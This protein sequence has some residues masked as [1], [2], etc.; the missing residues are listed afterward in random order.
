MRVICPLLVQVLARLLF[1]PVLF[2]YYLSLP[3]VVALIWCAR[4]EHRFLLRTYTAALLSAFHLPHTYPPYQTC[5]RRFQQWVR[6]GVLPKILR[7]LAKEIE[8]DLSE[9]FIDATFSSAKKG[10]HVS[11]RPNG[12][13]AR[14]LWQWQTL[15]DSHALQILLPPL[16]M[17]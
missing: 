2:G 16:P 5:H 4:N 1:E 9:T 15:L 10:A 11:G 7:K 13:R 3:A 12:A 6:A 17:K 14:K 8:L